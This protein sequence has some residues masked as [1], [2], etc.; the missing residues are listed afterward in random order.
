MSIIFRDNLPYKHNVACYPA[1]FSNTCYIHR[2]Y[3]FLF[4]VFV[5]LSKKRQ[6]Y[7]NG[8]NAIFSTT[9]SHYP[10]HYSIVCFLITY[11][12]MQ[13]LVSCPQ[14]VIKNFINQNSITQKNELKPPLI[15]IIQLHPIDILIV[16]GHKTIKIIDLIIQHIKSSFQNRVSNFQLRLIAKRSFVYYCRDYIHSIY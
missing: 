7:R 4:K 2:K 3:S 8:S 10:N 14:G 16:V 13:Q 11:I 12:S 9:I 15:N 6:F 1:L 5:Q